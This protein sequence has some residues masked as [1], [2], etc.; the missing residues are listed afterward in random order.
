MD[1]RPGEIKIP[2]LGELAVGFFVIVICLSAGISLVMA[3][4][5]GLESIWKR[6]SKKQ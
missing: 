5:E 4:I 3:I 1:L 6:F 2:S